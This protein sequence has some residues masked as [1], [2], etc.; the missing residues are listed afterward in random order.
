MRLPINIQVFVVRK[1]GDDYQYLML[2]RHKTMPNFWQPVSGGVE[3]FEAIEETARRELLEETGLLTELHNIHYSYS[4]PVE[5][6]W[7]SL[8]EWFTEHPEDL[9]IVVHNFVA[10]ADSAFVPT[11][12]GQEHDTFKWC[13]FEEALQTLYWDGDKESLSRVNAF[14]QK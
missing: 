9:T 8:Y 11:I 1:Q 6:I 10:I 14:L 5:D 3:E 4:F 13:S 2:H 7:T 12:D